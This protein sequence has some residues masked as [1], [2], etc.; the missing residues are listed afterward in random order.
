MIQQAKVTRPHKGKVYNFGI[1]VPRN[2][3]QVFEHDKANENKL[4]QDAMTK[5]IENIQVYKTFRDMGKV[6]FVDGYKQIIVHF[7]FAVKHKLCHKARLIAV[8]HLTVPTLEGSYSSVVSLHSLRL[9]LVA[10]ELNGLNTMVEDISSA[11]LKAYTKDKVCFIAGPEF[12]I[13]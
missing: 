12:G 11:Y 5:E 8:G 10:A 6:A 13:L 7:V 4:W 1:L 2:V 3:K 9:C